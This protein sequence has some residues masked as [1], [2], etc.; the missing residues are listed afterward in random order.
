MQQTI[1]REGKSENTHG[2]PYTDVK[3]VVL[4]IRILVTV[5][6]LAVYCHGDVKCGRH[7]SKIFDIHMFFK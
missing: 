5:V 6:L 2:D 7:K 1:Q 3:H 4:T